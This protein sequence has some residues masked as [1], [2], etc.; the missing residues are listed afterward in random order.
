[1]QFSIKPS[2]DTL[3]KYFDNRAVYV[4]E[5]TY[6]ETQEIF[7]PPIPYKQ[8]LENLLNLTDAN[9]HHYFSLKIHKD[10]SDKLHHTVFT[11]VTKQR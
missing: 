3:S 7:F 4:S 2:I 6:G 10:Q 11:I 5:G 9:N 1:M 8:F